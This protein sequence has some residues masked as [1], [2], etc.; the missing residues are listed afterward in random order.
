MRYVR[1]RFK[2]ESYTYFPVYLPRVK[3]SLNRRYKISARET[4]LPRKAYNMTAARLRSISRLMPTAS[5]VTLLDRVSDLRAM[6]D[7]AR[8][9]N[10]LNQALG[11]VSLFTLGVPV[12]NSW[13]VPDEDQEDQD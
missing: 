6:L 8:P 11:E 10:Q 13:E 5:S 9:K 2:Q 1:I 7:Y 3:G 4:L 12:F